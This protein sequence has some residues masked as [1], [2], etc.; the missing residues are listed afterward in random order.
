VVAVRDSRN[1]TGP[2]LVF[3]TAEWAVFVG[4]VRD[5]DFAVGRRQAV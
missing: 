3:T 2:A 1:P 5:G 4:G